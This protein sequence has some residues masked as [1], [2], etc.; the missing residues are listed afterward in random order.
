MWK[1]SNGY[2]QVA[3]YAT[4][5]TS[6]ASSSEM[7]G[8]AV[9]IRLLDPPLHEFLPN[10]P[11]VQQD[12]ADHMGISLE[13]LHRQDRACLHENNPM[14]G[15]RGCRLGITFPAITEMQAR[16]IFE[17]AIHVKRGRHRGIGPRSWCH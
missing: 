13:E 14:M 3:S 10:E 12:L 6:R 1:A 15:H 5:V 11:E 16:A 4:F 8:F 9:T 17:A 7:N 2:Q